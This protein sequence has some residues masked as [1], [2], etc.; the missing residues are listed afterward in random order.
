[1]FTLN[2]ILVAMC[3]RRIIKQRCYLL[4]SQKISMN[5]YVNPEISK[6]EE[7]VSEMKV[8][9]EEN[10]LNIINLNITNVQRVKIVEISLCFLIKNM[11]LL[12]NI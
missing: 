1:M 4:E 11:Y 10:L 8:K 5:Y 6:I 9:S 12:E 3:R 7:I 2:G